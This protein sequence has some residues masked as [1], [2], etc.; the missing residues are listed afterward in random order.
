MRA[1]LSIVL[2]TVSASAQS[3]SVTTSQNFGKASS[4]CQAPLF[5][6]LSQ[7]N[8][9][10]CLQQ[11]AM[12]GAAITGTDP[13]GLQNFCSSSCLPLFQSGYA[14]MGS[15]MD[16]YTPKLVADL[17]ADNVT[18]ATALAQTMIGSIRMLPEIFTMMCMRNERGDFCMPLFSRMGSDVAASGGTSN[19]TAVCNVYYNTG[20]CLTA[21]DHLYSTIT[22]NG[23]SFL[24]SLTRVCPVL[25]TFSPP[26]CLIYG[27][28]AV[29][30]R[31]ILPITSLNCVAYD[32][33]TDEFK[34][35]FETAL[36]NDLARQGPT[37]LWN[38]R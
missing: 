35:Q 9:Q 34:L 13:T 36:R 4:D 19:L 37:R 26:K 14:G 1:V 15:C 25:S 29:G 5:Q 31:V 33:Q 6:Q 24:S 16:A 27:Q 22:P 30:L 32:Q 11:M 21:L 7:K 18:N 28:A 17:T 10:G 8:N 2:F 3:A 12:V 23:V 38:Q 20:C